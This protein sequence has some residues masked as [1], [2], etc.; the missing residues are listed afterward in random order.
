MIAVLRS[1][2]GWFTLLLVAILA[3]YFAWLGSTAAAKLEAADLPEAATHHDVEVVLAIAPE[4]FH[5]TRLQAAGRLMRFEGNSAFIMDLPDAALEELARNYWVA[6][7][8]AWES[9]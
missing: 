5:M 9:Q 4:Q 3:V 6:A 1:P 2:P 8:H 7:I